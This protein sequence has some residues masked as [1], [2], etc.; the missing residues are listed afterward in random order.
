MPDPEWLYLG[1]GVYIMYD[2]FSVWLRTASHKDREFTNEIC[3][4][5]SVLS[6]INAFYETRR[7]E[8]KD[9]NPTS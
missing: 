3:L 9:A 8:A 4:E 7:Q 1:D 2:G 6:A 5:P